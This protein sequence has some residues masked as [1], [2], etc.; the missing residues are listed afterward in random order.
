MREAKQR[1]S[2][3]EPERDKR[4]ENAMYEVRTSERLNQQLLI[5]GYE[6][7]PEQIEEMLGRIT[8]AESFNY[9]CV[10]NGPKARN[11]LCLRLKRAHCC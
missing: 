9:K 1:L 3:C 11:V 5:Y 10:E 2:E 7:R 6:V 8:R 4:E